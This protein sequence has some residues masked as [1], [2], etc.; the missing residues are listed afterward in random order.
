MPEQTKVAMPEGSWA[1]IKK[2]IRGYYAKRDS[3]EV[4]VQ[5]VA[6][7]ANL[8]RPLISSNNNFLKYLGILE[9]DSYRLT[10]LGS[11]FAL[12]LV[13]N[14]IETQAYA[15]RR[16]VEQVPSIK[17]LFEVVEA[18]GGISADAFK[19]QV[20]MVWN[21]DP[22]DRRVMW[23]GTL[24]EIL[25]ESGL[26][27]VD[28]DAIRPGGRAYLPPSNGLKV[29]PPKREP[30]MHTGSL[31]LHKI[32][33]AVSPTDIWYVEVS[34]NPEPEQVGKFLE[35]QRLIFGIKSGGQS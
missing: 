8:S 3:A 9:Q 23:L 26:L 1:T 13:R 27:F 29:E 30:N 18:R 21:L 28:D 22:Q 16:L 20:L 25:Q 5:D 34:Q 15:L 31:G 12:A 33:I 14:D 7:A 19:T 35:M 32:P 10:P 2:I 4:K 24:L 6:T 17:K 11:E